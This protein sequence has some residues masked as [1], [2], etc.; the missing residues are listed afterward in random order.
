MQF[1]AKHYST[2]CCW[3]QHHVAADLQNIIKTLKNADKL[4]SMML[5]QTNLVRLLLLG[6][7]ECRTEF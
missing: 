3:Y 2:Q 1:L 7:E 6:L 5:S 4:S